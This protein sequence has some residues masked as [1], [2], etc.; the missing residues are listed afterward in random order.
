MERGEGCSKEVG[1][2]RESL[3]DGATIRSQA[4]RLGANY[5]KPI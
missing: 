4:R 5:L 3:R 2:P 1:A